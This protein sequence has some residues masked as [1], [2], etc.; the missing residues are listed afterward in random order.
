MCA[1]PRE[2]IQGINRLYEALWAQ[3][4]CWDREYSLMPEIVGGVPQNVVLVDPKRVPR[5]RLMSKEGL[6]AMLHAITHIEFNAINIALDAIYRFRAM[7]LKYYI[8]WLRIAKEEAYHFH[9]LSQHLHNLGYHYGDFPA[10]NGLWEMVQK[11]GYDVLVRMAL[12]P[13]LLEARGL[14]VTPDIAKRLFHAGDTIAAEILNIIFHD[15][16]SHVAVGNHWYHYLCQQRNVD[17]LVT[18]IDLLQQHGP[19]YLRGPFRIDA[20]RKAGFSESELNWLNKS[21]EPA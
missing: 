1:E 3:E 2:K 6:A 11:T 20:R 15:E 17:P 8:D 16:I 21:I 9:L 7:P 12:V 14:D 18:F 5:R 13:R 19:T 10:H 4:L